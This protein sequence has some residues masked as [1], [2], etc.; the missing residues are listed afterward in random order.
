MLVIPFPDKHCEWGRV[1]QRTVHHLEPLHHQLLDREL[2]GRVH[3]RVQ[4]DGLGV[5]RLAPRRQRRCALRDH[6]VPACHPRWLQLGNPPEIF[7]EEGYTDAFDYVQKGQLLDVT[8]WMNQ[9]GNGDRLLK[10]SLP[11]VT[12]VDGKIYGIPELIQTTGSI[13]YDKKVLAANGIDPTTLKNWNDY[14]AAFAKLK[15][16]GVTPLAYGAKDG[17]PGSE[18]YFSFLGKLAGGIHEMQLAAGNCGYKWTDPV[19]VQAAQM[20]LDLKNK[21]YFSAGAAGRDWNAS[22]AEFL[23][24]KAGFYAMGSWFISNIEGA[25]NA[26]DFGLLTFPDVPGGKGGQ[27]TQLVAPQGFAITVSAKD[28]AKKAAALAFIS[29]VDNAANQAILNKAGAEI[30]AV[31]AANVGSLSPLAT[32]IVNEQI[33]PAT[34]SY[35]FLEHATTIA[36]GEDAIWKGSIGVLTGQLTAQSWM[37]SVQAADDST[38]GQNSFKVTPNCSAN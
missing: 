12:Y 6:G 32:Q 28:P 4:A 38:K 10:S 23:A 9:P 7:D 3:R 5:Q 11:S 25:P 33:S 27:S 19:S 20:Y 17:W 31:A 29:F 13:W 30:S 26:S 18:W 24:G 2:L 16:A 14:L 21:G 15:S 1:R 8:D 22:S 34:E 37:Q 36:T 35:T